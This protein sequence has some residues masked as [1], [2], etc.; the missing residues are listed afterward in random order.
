MT[1]AR[2]GEISEEWEKNWGEGDDPFD[3]LKKSVS[4]DA[5]FLGGGVF[6]WADKH[7]TDEVQVDWGSWAWKCKG[8][9]LIEL[10]KRHPW[11]H[12][13]EIED[14]DPEKTYGVVLIEM[15]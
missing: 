4:L 15:Y 12:R 3:V 9:E 7:C 5:F 2:C 6:G 14:M 1:Q 11:C 8:K 10:N 13:A